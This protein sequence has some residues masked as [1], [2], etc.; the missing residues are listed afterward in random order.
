MLK[1]IKYI[2][3]FIL[4]F[5]FILFFNSNVKANSNY[6]E[7]DCKKAYDLSCKYFSDNNLTVYDYVI[8]SNYNEPYL[9][10]YLF[11]N[12]NY[13]CC[14]RNHNSNLSIECNWVTIFQYKN[15]NSSLGYEFSVATSTDSKAYVFTLAEG[16]K[17]SSFDIYKNDGSLY[18][19][20]NDAF[21]NSLFYL[22]YNENLNSYV[23]YSKW[24]DLVEDLQAKNMYRF[25]Y[26]INPSNV[27]TSFDFNNRDDD[28]WISMEV[29][30]IGPGLEYDVDDEYMNNITSKEQLEGVHW[31]NGLQIVEYGTYYF[32][33]YNIGTEQ[34]KNYEIIKYVF[35][36][37]GNSYTETL[38]QNTGT[39]GN[40]T[41]ID[42][43]T[44]T[45]LKENINQ[46]TSYDYFKVF[47]EECYQDALIYTNWFLS[48]NGYNYVVTYSSDNI[49]FY[50]D[51]FMEENNSGVNSFRYSFSVQ[52]NATYYIRLQIYD[53]NN[54]LVKTKTLQ[55]KIRAIGV[56]DYRSDDTDVEYR[57]NNNSV[58]KFLKN[59][60]GALFYPIDL[61]F[62]FFNR[63]DMIDKVEPTIT[64]PTVR[65]YFTNA[66]IINGFT[67]NLN[68]V[69]QNNTFAEVY[70]IYLNIVDFILFIAITYHLYK[71]LK[72]FINFGG[73]LI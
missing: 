23:V 49:H 7:E 20:K 38:D 71:V 9:Y 43:N 53:S 19:S 37:E 55:V 21:K 3:L 33:C 25:F 62:D 69:L 17:Y 29:N 68:S 70:N 51:V 50:K 30:D 13:F 4:M 36:E 66:V 61:L 12:E 46:Q 54:S 47:Y 73:G 56:K 59:N 41:N 28:G 58:Y 11:K 60:L 44:N 10:V 48:D 39:W 67:Y 64:V 65:E 18:F 45:S 1:K 40:T 16:L 31:R 42:N 5:L 26:Q 35:N 14:V 63:L 22:E 27:P 57:L 2:V 52:Q 15:N 32:C 72:E 24:V 8:S 6:S 34:S